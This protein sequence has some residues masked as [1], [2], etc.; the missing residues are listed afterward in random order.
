MRLSRVFNGL[1]LVLLCLG[2]KG[3]DNDKYFM[4]PVRPG[5][6]N[7]LAGTMGEL[8]SSHFHSAIDIKTSGIQ[9]LPIYAAAGGYISRIK[10]SSGGYGNALYLS[11]PNGT[12]TVYA[13]L[14]RFD[15]GVAQYVRENQYAKESFEVDMHLGPN[16]FRFEQG[17]TIA[18]SGNSGSS[19]GPHLHFEIRDKDHKVLNPLN[20]YFSEIKD[21]I[22]PTVQRIALATLGIKSRIN[23]RFGRFEF[24]VVR[25]GHTF[26]IPQSIAVTGSIGIE[27]L[28][29]DKLDG[30]SNK[31]G[32]PYI[33]LRQ[34]D[35][36][37]FKQNITTFSFAKT[38]NLFVHTNY[39]TMVSTK[40]RFAKLYVDDGNEL[41]FYTTNNNSGRIVVLDTLTHNLFITMQDAYG[42]ESSV[43]FKLKGAP[44]TVGNLLRTTNPG[45]TKR[46]KII[47]NTLVLKSK[48]VG[49]E[50]KLVEVHL[51]SR[52]YDLAPAYLEKQDAVYLW[53]LR[54]G[55]PDSINM[56]YEY[57][58]CRFSAVVPSYRDFSYFNNRMDVSFYKNSLFDTLYLQKNYQLGLEDS[59]EVFTIGNT[60][61]PLRRSAKVALKPVLEYPENEKTR[62]Y[63]KYSSKGY[64][65]VGGEWLENKI[66]FTTRSLGDFTLL[67]DSIAP[68]IKVLAQDHSRLR[69]AI[70]DNLSGIKSYEVTVDG[71]W[72]LMNYDQKQNL[73]WSEKL[74]QN[75]P[76]EGELTLRVID[77]SGNQKTYRTKI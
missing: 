47:N 57:E 39:A 56:C 24:P 43:V 44:N 71:K 51:G 5:E 10:V 26:S 62:V 36:P 4:F 33:E 50:L 14:Q 49:D 18:Y 32:I 22:P 45:T 19:S 21:H 61:I 7:F 68:T 42:N 27:L 34:N 6:D 76:F 15:P 29:H 35:E 30:A 72:I 46:S 23:G 55:L 28:A 73:I 12:S 64:E 67:T 13:H 77:N 31:N 9:G 37:I 63:R 52:K 16:K 1:F 59:K 40:R 58:Y 2:A 38:R 69:F 3:P 48:V 54:D 74:D 20:Y 53:D 75:I 11:H 60:L 66:H 17:D 70:K 41:D 8:R 65:Y 25:K